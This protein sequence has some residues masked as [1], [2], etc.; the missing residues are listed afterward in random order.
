[1]KKNSCTHTLKIRVKR[2]PGKALLDIDGYSII[3]H[4]AKRAMLSK[5]INEVYVC[6]DS[7]EIIEAC[8]KYNILTIKTKEF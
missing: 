5:M 3:V 7:D 1:M 8:K 2:L 6:T 4:T